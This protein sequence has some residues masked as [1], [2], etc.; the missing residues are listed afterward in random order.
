[1]REHHYVN[2]VHSDAY[3]FTYLDN[4]KAGTSSVRSWMS[5]ILNVSWL[6]VPSGCRALMGRTHSG[7][8]VHSSGTTTVFGVVREPFSK[9]ESG[10]RQ[11]FS[12]RWRSAEQQAWFTTRNAD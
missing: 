1:M 10:V 6:K 4:V 9:F 5:E 11:V 8:Y 3:N 2:V 7:C 12:A